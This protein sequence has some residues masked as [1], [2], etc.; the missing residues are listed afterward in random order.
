MNDVGSHVVFAGRNKNF[1]AGNFGPSACFTAWCAAQTD[2]RAAVRFGQ[3]HG[4]RPFAG[5]DFRDV[6]LLVVLVCRRAAGRWWAHASPDTCIHAQLAAIIIS[7][8]AVP[9]ELG[10]P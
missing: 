7:P 4:T 9:S 10:K 8:I 3:T 6:E 5:D 2:I 1:G